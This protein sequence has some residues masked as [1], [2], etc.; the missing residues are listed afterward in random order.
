MRRNERGKM[1]VIGLISV[2]ILG[3]AIYVLGD[4]GS[5]YWQWYKIR[6]AALDVAR[7]SVGVQE[8][9][10]KTNVAKE[11]K[12]LGIDKVKNLK[13]SRDTYDDSKI[14]ITFSYDRTI[15]MRHHG[16]RTKNFDVDV[17]V[18]LPMG[19]KGKM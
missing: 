17:E 1:G 12:L 5:A 3:Y 10:L 13:M 19:G 14:N 7:F 6:S 16:Q 15:D 2:A 8:R 18:G 4:W 11:V 9:T